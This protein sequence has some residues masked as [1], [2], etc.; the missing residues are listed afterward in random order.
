MISDNQPADGA[1]K[2]LPGDETA[3]GTK[4][5]AEGICPACAGTG[6]LGRQTCPDCGGTGTIT[7]IVGDA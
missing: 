7:V 2:L 6:R 4:Q 3:P 5:A 1:Q